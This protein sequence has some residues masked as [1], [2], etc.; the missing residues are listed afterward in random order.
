MP[1]EQPDITL[2][3][4]GEGPPLKTLAIIWP[5][6]EAKI[7]TPAKANSETNISILS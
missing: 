5:Q 3:A 2:L 6:P 1:H 4:F 7:R